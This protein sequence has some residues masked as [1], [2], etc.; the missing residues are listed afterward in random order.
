MAGPVVRS[1]VF[2]GADAI[3]VLK[4]NGQSSVVSHQGVRVYEADR[5]NQ[6]QRRRAVIGFLA[7]SSGQEVLAYVFAISARIGS[8]TLRTLLI[9][10]HVL[11]RSSESLPCVQRARASGSTETTAVSYGSKRSNN[12]VQSRTVTTSSSCILLHRGRHRRHYG[13]SPFPFPAET[14]RT[15]RLLNGVGRLLQ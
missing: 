6:K 11:P 15:L 14:S 5:C 1:V 13:R 7:T 12:I 3:T 10:R 4:K 2:R 8:S 9:D